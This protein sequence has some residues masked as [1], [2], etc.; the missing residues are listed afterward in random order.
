M[1]Q[2]NTCSVF[3]GREKTGGAL[4]STRGKQEGG[5][6]WRLLVSVSFLLIP[7]HSWVLDL[8]L[9]KCTFKLCRSTA[10]TYAF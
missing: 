6:W 10:L 9:A 4:L 5:W 1:C 8:K 3:G 2:A 7:A